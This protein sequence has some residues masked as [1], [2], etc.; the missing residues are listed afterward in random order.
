MQ[1]LIALLLWLQPPQDITFT[2]LHTNDEHSALIPAPLAT[3]ETALG[4]MARLAT[5]LGYW[6]SKKNTENEPVFVL[7]GGDIS[8]GTPFNW[9]VFKGEAPELELMLDLKY[10][11]ITLGNHEFD[12]GPDV[13]VS[14]LKK[15]GYPAKA[16]T[17]PLVS[18]NMII[19]D[20]HPL[21]EMGITPSHVA[22]LPS[23]HKIGF[24]GLM[25]MD[26]AEVAPYK[27]PISFAPLA[28]TTRSEIERLKAQGV[29]IFIAV[30][31]SGVEEDIQLAKD[32]P[33]LHLIV[34]GHSHTLIPEP[35]RVNNTLIVQAGS[36]LQYLGILEIAYDPEKGT[37]RLLNEERGNPYVKALSDGVESDSTMAEKVRAFEKALDGAIAEWTSGQV[38]N[39]RAI[40]SETAFAIPSTPVLQETP[41]GNFVTDA[42]RMGVQNA[43]SE[44]VDVA[45]LA[46]GVIR[47]DFPAGPIPFYDVASYTGLGSGPDKSPGYP[48]VSMYFT[49]TEV[50]RI[51]EITILL[52]QF[53]GD[54]YY[55][56]SSGL[57]YEFDVDRAI[58]LRIPFVGTPIPASKAV[59]K[60]WFYT[61]EGVQGNFPEQ[62][63]SLEWDDDRLYHVVSDY[64]NASFLPFVGTIIPN[65]QLVFKDRNGDPVQ[66]D[67]RIVYRDGKPYKVWQ[68]VAEYAMANPIIPASYQA[69]FQRQVPVNKLHMLFWPGFI[70]GVLVAGL[71]ILFLKRRTSRIAPRAS[72]N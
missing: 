52:S 68:A 41:M 57:R 5:E 4:G 1:L 55:L 48:L 62:F 61:G 50:R 38:T 2:I 49:G 72:N 27:D 47:G 18:A 10:D 44:R 40:L 53:R 70:L 7:S 69:E 12:Y 20:G 16:T 29:T 39:H 25:G 36:L 30:T 23:G 64:Y 42:I 56:Q 19:P 60:A 54:T 71:I 14:Y 3:P 8:T 37:I 6:R 32:V 67:D 35:M 46:N 59:S 63:E 9:L 22:E 15:A 33:E 45:F 17:T 13:L 65:L 26:A 24:I 51:I 58:W 66:L 31:H 34:G 43:M 21:G 11:V 28:E